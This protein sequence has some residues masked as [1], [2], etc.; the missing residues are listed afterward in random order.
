[1]TSS[2]KTCLSRESRWEENLQAEVTLMT[3]TCVSLKEPLSRSVFASSEMQD[4]LEK[5]QAILRIHNTPISTVPP[6]TGDYRWQLIDLEYATPVD[7]AAE[8]YVHGPLD[9]AR[10]LP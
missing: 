1:M 6:A 3:D 5:R 8:Q 4:D 2:H 7:D 10:R 9:C